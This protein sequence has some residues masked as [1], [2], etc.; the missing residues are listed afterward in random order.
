MP[1]S[2]KFQAAMQHD[3]AQGSALAMAGVFVLSFDALLIRLAMADPWDI[4]FWRGLLMGLALGL[5]AFGRT[6]SFFL[7]TLHRHGRAAYLSGTL[8]GLS[9]VGFVLSI[10]NTH[11]ANTVLIF[12]AAPLFAALFTWIFLRERIQAKTWLAILAVICGVGLVFQGSLQA[13]NLNGDLYALTAALI[14]GAN[15]T[16]LRRHPHLERTPVV[17]WGGFISAFLAFFWAEPFSLA[18][19]SYLV[20]ALMGLVQMPLALILLAVSTRKLSSPEVSMVLLLEAVLGPFWVWLILGESPP[21]PTWLGGAI[22]LSTL[23]VYFSWSLR[24]NQKS[25][26]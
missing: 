26:H 7:L 4:L 1:K 14:V 21:G 15:F 16:L 18:P 10:M 5:A 2:D 20:L 11:V 24:S 25:A 8:F 9:G 19:E 13:G 12:S 3:T 22:I 23:A 17:A 6:K